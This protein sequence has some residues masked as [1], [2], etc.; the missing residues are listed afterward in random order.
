MNPAVEANSSVDEDQEQD[1]EDVTDDEHDITHRV[2]L[3]SCRG[4]KSGKAKPSRRTRK[5]PD[6]PHKQVKNFGEET[7]VDFIPNPPQ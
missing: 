2:K 6:S 1:S 7:P 5:G 3:K 4:C